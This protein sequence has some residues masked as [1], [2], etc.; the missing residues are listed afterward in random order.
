MDT[1]EESNFISITMNYRRI[2]LDI[3]TIQYV[4]INQNTAEFHISGGTQ[5]KTR[6]PIHKLEAMLG[7]EF[8]RVHRNYLVAVKAIHDISDKVYLNNGEA[9]HFAMR[10]KKELAVELRLKRQILLERLAAG[11]T[12]HTDEEYHARFAIFDELPIA[13]CDIEMVL[14][15][16]NNAVDWIFRY[17]NEAL[18]K[19]EKT[20]LNEL[21]GKTFSSIFPDM[22]KKW[23]KSY[24]QAALYKQ[25][26]QIID[27]SPE[28]D[29]YLNI[30]CFPTQHGHCGCILLDIKEME[31]AENQGDREN[32]R[33]HYFAK[34]LESIV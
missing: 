24:E 9:L 14:D 20:P 10:R 27:F 7:D 18:A 16:G 31:Y 3:R 21:I 32:A 23:L 29:T 13:F 22:D 19:L 1:L 11:N 28:I 5:Y 34:L 26:L 4:V 30:L 33:L 25:T 6:I 2:N 17:G 15:E 12:T 8:I